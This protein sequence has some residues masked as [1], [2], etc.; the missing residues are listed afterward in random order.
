M[1]GVNLEDPDELWARLTEEERSEFDR[2]ARSGDVS[3]VLPDYQPWW[4]VKVQAKKIRELDEMEE[5]KM[6]MKN[7]PPLEKEIP[8][9]SQLCP[10]PSEFIKFGIFN[11]LYAYAYAVKFLLGDYAEETLD[12]VNIVQLLSKNLSGHNY[13][14]VDTALESAAS[15][16]NNH[17]QLTISLQFS[18]QVKGDV[19]QI[20]R[21]PGLSG[22]HSYYVM[23]ALSD[24]KR[25][26]SKAGK[27]LKK[28]AKQ[29][30]VSPDMSAPAWLQT[31]RNKPQLKA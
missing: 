20:I 28:V 6:F 15:E 4:S 18:R 31:N 22:S 5:E 7:C 21:G 17:P 23:A 12:L 25:L 27:S 30:K 29:K 9:L 3:S 10:N 13:S 2:L 26:F 1:R 8:P 14:D 19:L 16:V 11:I 24:L